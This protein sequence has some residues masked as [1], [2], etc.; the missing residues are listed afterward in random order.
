MV[1]EGNTYLAGMCGLHQ[2]RR[3][4]SYRHNPFETPVW[5][6]PSFRATLRRKFIL[7]ANQR[8]KGELTSVTRREIRKSVVYYSI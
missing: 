8:D 4:A 5:R 3:R 2:Y 7:K 1:W 6:V